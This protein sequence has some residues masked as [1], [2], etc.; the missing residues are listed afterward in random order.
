MMS[1]SFAWKLVLA[2]ALAGT[3]IASARARA[4]QRQIPAHDLHRLVF[5][6]LV[7]YVIGLVASL[8]HHQLL[9]AVL[10]VG[11]IGASALAAWLSRGAGWDGPDA[12]DDPGEEPPGPEPEGAPSFDWRAFERE[13]R[14]Y[15]RRRRRPRSPVA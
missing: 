9:A 6:A 5:A 10:Y 7:L 13:F 11:G 2:V 14:A 15:D 12:G 4:P 3:I 8:S 1:P